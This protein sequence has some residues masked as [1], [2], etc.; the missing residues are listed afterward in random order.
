[1]SIRNVPLS[2]FFG[3]KRATLMLHKHMYRICIPHPL[4]FRVSMALSS[5]Q[6]KQKNTWVMHVFKENRRPNVVFTQPAV[7]ATCWGW[8]KVSDTASTK[9][10]AMPKHSA[11]LPCSIS[12]ALCIWVLLCQFRLGQTYRPCPLALAAHWQGN[13]LKGIAAQQDLLLTHANDFR[14]QL[15][16]PCRLWDGVPSS[17]SQEKE[18]WI[19]QHHPHERGMFQFD[20]LYS[21]VKRTAPTSHFGSSPE[22]V[23]LSV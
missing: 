13:E 14:T 22:F 6:L 21:A 9:Q 7:K 12:P 18:S 10:R 4:Q 5:P 3:S 20:A 23:S 16:E 17:G 2:T 11:L 8:G 19:K 1:M 15:T